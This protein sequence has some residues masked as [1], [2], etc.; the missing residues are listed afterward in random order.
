MTRQP[1]AITALA[2]SCLWAL[3]CDR[4]AP[5]PPTRQAST[6]SQASAASASA[7]APA[8]AFEFNCENGKVVLGLGY[9]GFH[10]QSLAF[11]GTPPSATPATLAAT[12]CAKMPELNLC[13]DDE[14]KPGV[15][16]S[17]VELRLTLSEGRVARVRGTPD[18]PALNACIGKVLERAAADS[19]GEVVYRY[20]VSVN[21][22]RVGSAHR[23]DAPTVEQRDVKVTGALPL[24]VVTRIMRANTRSLRECYD[25]ARAATPALYGTIDIGFAIEGNGNAADVKVRGGTL[26]DDATRVCTTKVLQGLKFPEPETG[27]VQVTATLAFA[28]R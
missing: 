28:P 10:T 2:A 18:R 4:T 22:G 13:I 8:Q 16:L 6:A 12:V 19:D 5:A 17:A 14:K 20:L 7:A 25:T 3:A 9:G 15:E 26:T 24:E 23:A 27:K 21:R 1:R 11:V